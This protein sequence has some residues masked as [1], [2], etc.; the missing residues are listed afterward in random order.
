[1]KEQLEQ[2]LK[3][4][5]PQLLGRLPYFECGDGWYNILNSMCFCIQQNISQKSKDNPELLEFR[6][7]QIKEKFGGLRA[8][9]IGYDDY[10]N[11]IIRMAETMS[12]VTCE[13]CGSPGKTRKTGWWAV[14][15]D[16]CQSVYKKAKGITED[17]KDEDE[18][19]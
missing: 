3:T 16:N 19:D 9:A 15:C 10:S 8:Y 4:M 6:F 1:M 18:E 13:S 11:A 17:E 5:Y 7:V 12:D 2:E 14:R